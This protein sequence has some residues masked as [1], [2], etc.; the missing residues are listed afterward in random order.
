MSR[1][2]MDEV[3][4]QDEKPP[5]PQLRRHTLIGA[6]DNPCRDQRVVAGGGARKCKVCSGGI[7]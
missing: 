7:G 3:R 1:E 5:K 4:K 6:G 2:I